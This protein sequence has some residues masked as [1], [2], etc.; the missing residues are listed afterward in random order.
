MHANIVHP[1]AMVV[2]IDKLWHDWRC[3]FDKHTDKLLSL[4][5]IWMDSHIF[6]NSHLTYKTILAFL[7]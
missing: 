4:S 6:Q 7:I 2:G 3:S 5:M 1:S